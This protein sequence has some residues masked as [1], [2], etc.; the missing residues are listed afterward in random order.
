MQV[1]KDG[2]KIITFIFLVNN[3]VENENVA[4]PV[5]HVIGGL[6]IYIYVHMIEN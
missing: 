4:L 5:I 2:G 1:W 6:N 3:T